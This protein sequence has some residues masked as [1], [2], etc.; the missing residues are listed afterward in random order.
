M[1]FRLASTITTQA[2]TE[3]GLTLEQ[4]QAIVEK[5]EAEYNGHVQLSY[6][7]AATQKEVYGDAR[8]ED[9][10][11]VIIKGAYH[12]TGR[13]RREGNPIERAIDSRAR[14]QRGL[15]ARSPNAVQGPRGR[16]VLVAENLASE[17]D[18]LETLRHEVLG[19]FGLNT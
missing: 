8:D 19:H 2:K 13:R 15:V 12:P 18:L 3:Q 11:P 5:F 7:V 6:R 4:A 9:G 10:K 16:V 1:L 14:E 17:A